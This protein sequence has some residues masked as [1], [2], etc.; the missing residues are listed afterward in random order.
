MDENPSS[1][2]AS[3]T[4]RSAA[5]QLQKKFSQPAE[6][7]AKAVKSGENAPQGRPIPPE[8]PPNRMQIFAVSGVF[9]ALCGQDSRGAIRNNCVACPIRACATST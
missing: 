1:T 3:G 9:Q 7:A 5:L 8:S 4:A 6:N 2:H